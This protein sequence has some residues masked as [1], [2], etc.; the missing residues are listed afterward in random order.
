MKSIFKCFM[1]FIVVFMVSCSLAISDEYVISESFNNYSIDELSEEQA[2]YNILEDNVGPTTTGE[3]E[4][5]YNKYDMYDDNNE[6]STTEVIVKEWKYDQLPSIQEGEFVTGTSVVM[7]N[8][9]SQWYSMSGLRYKLNYMCNSMGVAFDYLNIDDEDAHI[10]IIVQKIVDGN[11]NWEETYNLTGY[12]SW[13]VDW[14]EIN[15]SADRIDEKIIKG[16]E[17]NVVWLVAT[18]LSINSAYGSYLDNL[19]LTLNTVD[20]ILTMKPEEGNRELIPEE[21]TNTEID[22]DV[23]TG[24]LY[25][26][27][28]CPSDNNWKNHG[29]YVSCVANALN[30]LALLGYSEESLENLVS[31]AAQSDVGKNNKNRNKFTYNKH[32]P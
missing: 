13:N 6:L 26:E 16:R 9:I 7:T 31:M 15:Y 27:S 19:N 10:T 32:K 18:E 11:I 30:D 8:G 28:Q 1:V 24:I 14:Q 21:D 5:I 17:F 4:V 29:K 3:P 25:I 12:K 22:Q 23:L 2:R 20:P